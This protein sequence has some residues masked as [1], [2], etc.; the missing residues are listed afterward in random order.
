MAFIME[1]DN[2][3]EEMMSMKER[4]GANSNELNQTYLRLKQM[5]AGGPQFIDTFM[6]WLNQ[7]GAQ[8]YLR[9][10]EDFMIFIEHCVPIDKCNSRITQGICKSINRWKSIKRR[11]LKIKYSDSSQKRQKNKKLVTISLQL[12]VRV[13]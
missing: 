8:V 9:K 1:F 11:Q 13:F 6:K 10:T 4:R 2:E 5:Q 3:M 7:V 12:P